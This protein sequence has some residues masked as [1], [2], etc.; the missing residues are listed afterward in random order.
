VALSFPVSV[1][2]IRPK[3]SD[4]TSFNRPSFGIRLDAGF[5]SFLT[6]YL[7]LRRTSAM[8]HDGSIRSG[9][10]MG[11]GIQLAAPKCRILKICK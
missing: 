5:T 6:F 3:G 9:P 7:E 4:D 8:Q 2:H 11:A 1:Q 10:A